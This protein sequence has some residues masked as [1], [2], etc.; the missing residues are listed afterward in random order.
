MPRVCKTCGRVVAEAAYCPFCS[1]ATIE[2]VPL[3][4]EPTIEH[5]PASF[6]R[7]YAETLRTLVERKKRSDTGFASVCFLSA[8]GGV[9]LVALLHIYLNISMAFLC[10]AYIAAFLIPAIF[11][12]SFIFRCPR[13]DKDLVPFAMQGNFVGTGQN[14]RFCPFCGLD[15][16]EKIDP[17]SH[18]PS[19]FLGRESEQGEFE[20]KNT[21]IQL[22]HG[23]QTASTDIQLSPGKEGKGT[24]K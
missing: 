23:K 22:P 8:L 18:E 9:L 20:I 16:D 3:C 11:A 1:E 12:P 24:A 15:L 14:L 21:A 2:H 4:S 10:I 7:S 5:V 17:R 6:K 13:C 19:E